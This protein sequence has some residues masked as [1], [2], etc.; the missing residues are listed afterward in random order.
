LA[1]LRRFVQDRADLAGV[2][3]HRIDDLVYA[4][5]E[6]VTNS[7]CHGAGHAELSAWT[8][9]DW[10]CCEVRDRG[11]ITDPMAG[12]IPPRSGDGSGR[13]LWLIHHLCD[14]VQVRSSGAGTTVRMR[15]DRRPT[16]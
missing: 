7:I 8:E 10:F 2:E 12:R 3:P 6:A 16:R 14:L 13:G 5:N 15:I 4:V 1:A 9:D 11:R